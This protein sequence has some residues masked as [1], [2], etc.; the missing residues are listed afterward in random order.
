[1]PSVR[2]LA[3]C[4]LAPTFVA[5][6]STPLAAMDAG[7][8]QIHGFA[9]QGY[10]YTP[11]DNTFVSPN[12]NSGGT[13]DFNEFAVNFSATPVE[14]LRVGAQLFANTFGKYGKDKVQL[15]W[16]YGEYQVPISSDVVELSVL[17][18]R[19]KMGHGLYN[20]YRDLDMTR[21]TVFLPMAVYSASFRDVFLAVNGVGE[22][23]TFRPAGLGSFQ[24]YAF[25]GGQ[26]VDKDGP[27]GDAF[28]IPS[29]GISGIDSIA[30][31]R[32]DGASLTWETP[33]EGLKLKGSI[34]QSYG[35]D[36][37]AYSEIVASGRVV[38]L[39]ITYSLP[40]YI[41]TIVGFEYQHG[42]FLVASEYTNARSE[43]IADYSALGLGQTTSEL[44]QE[45]L[46]GSASYHFLG[47]FD[48][49]IGESWNHSKS[50]VETVASRTVS[51]IFALRCDITEHW[52]VKAEFQRN[53]GTLD[54]TTGTQEFWNLFALKTTFD[55]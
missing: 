16:G 44:N 6:L 50:D 9:S 10:L 29:R 18:G 47:R 51:T 3:V 33:L 40:N 39:P 38:R 1:M 48:G 43:I 12:S 23:L 42:D 41:N 19:I 32:E 26:N 53:K 36:V 27:L 13:F 54:A 49:L 15:D 22:N 17:A 8:V 21:T 11:G 35:I 24:L 52:L 2:T 28:N 30:I 31:R 55:F 46:Y 37:N 25:I 14:R 7:G 20:D 5:L 4:T 45:G 34:L